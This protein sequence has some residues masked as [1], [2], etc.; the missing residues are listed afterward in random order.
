MQGRRVRSTE[1]LEKKG[2]YCVS[3][4][5]DGRIASVWMVLPFKDLD[6]PVQACWGRILGQGS[7]DEGPKWE[8]TEDSDGKVTVR[9]SILTKFTYADIGREWHGYL[10][11][12]EMVSV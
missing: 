8:I 1:D 9:P 5:D 2:D 7:I 4:S 10:T 12:G 6:L 3:Y 11:S